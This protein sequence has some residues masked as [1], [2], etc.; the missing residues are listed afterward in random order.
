[1]KQ[2]RSKRGSYTGK[3]AKERREKQVQR[4]QHILAI[5]K[6]EI[7]EELPEALAPELFNDIKEQYWECLQAIQDPRDASRRVYPLYLILHR[8]ISGFIDGNRYIGVLFPIKRETLEAGKKKLGALPTR[9]VVYDLLKRID[10][11]EANA[12]LS[13][14][15][16]RLGF[17]PDL[18]V[19]RNFRDPK[20]V[21]EEYR[22]EKAEEETEK[23][24]K[25]AE[26]R[27]AEEKLKG[28]SA[29]KAKSSKV[30]ASPQSEVKSTTTSTLEKESQPIVIQ[31][32]LVIDGKV[33]KASYNNGVKERFVHVTEIRK[34]EN[35]NRSRF[36]IGA[37][38]TVL[39]RNG[40]WGAAMSILDSL[41][42]L[43]G[44]RI[45]VVSGDAGF[46]VEEFCNWLHYR[47]FFT[48]SD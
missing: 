46:S 36:I 34:D 11:T 26:E 28:M 47:G 23:R 37:Y 42:P 20:E 38:P 13:P 15:W 48:Y 41:V 6:G 24:K 43:P 22:S 19:R 32:D 44:D 30:A 25:I 31:H 39:D 17:T 1:M 29:A 16:E 33:V 10:W 35:D 7:S 45:I 5:E 2:Q 27:E 14:L 9:K 18:V 3:K 12:T 21:L 4:Q 40:E 8:I